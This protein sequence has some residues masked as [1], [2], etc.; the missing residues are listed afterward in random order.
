MNMKEG[1]RRMQRA[2]RATVI[3]SLSAF[4]LCAIAAGVYAFL[5]S[6]LHVTEVFGIVLPMLLTA[7]WICATTTGLGTILWLGGWILD[8]FHN[9]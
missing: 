7:I 1:A 3:L 8:G 5:P 9:E 6:S 4:A 2:G